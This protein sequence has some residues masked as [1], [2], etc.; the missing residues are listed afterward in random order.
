MSSRAARL[1]IDAHV[2]HH[3][4]EESPVTGRSVQ[5]N[6]NARPSSRRRA[7]SRPAAW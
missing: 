6:V 5:P 7:M 2:L 3:T 1:S 4:I